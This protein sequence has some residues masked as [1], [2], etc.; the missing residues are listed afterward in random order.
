MKKIFFFAMACLVMCLASCNS[1]KSEKNELVSGIFSVT[2]QSENG[3]TL[4][5][6]FSAEGTEIIAPQ[7]GVKFSMDDYNMVI[8][9]LPKDGTD[10]S[11][12]TLTGKQITDGPIKDFATPKAGYEKVVFIGTKPG[13]QVVIYFPD[14]EATILTKVQFIDDP[15]ATLGYEV[16]DGFVLRS[17]K[18]DAGD[19]YTFKDKNLFFLTCE[20]KDPKVVVPGKRTATVYDVAGKKEKSIPITTWKKA[21]K[22]AQDVKKLEGITLCRVAK[23]F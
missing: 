22:K 11:Y 9:A 13:G 21:M 1:F 2:S 4:C 5:G 14:T 19:P 10:P 6:V 16:S 7:A 17:L 18:K 3:D 15:S 8:Q 12:Y 20:G 23:P